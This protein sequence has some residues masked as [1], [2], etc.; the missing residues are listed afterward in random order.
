MIIKIFILNIKYYFK[1]KVIN[2]NSD[3]AQK[4]ELLYTKNLIKNY[5]YVS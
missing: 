1:N 3:F 4:G 5:D 2:K